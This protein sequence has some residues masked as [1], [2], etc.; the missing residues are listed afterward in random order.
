M[1]HLRVRKQLL[2]Y[3]EIRVVLFDNFQVAEPTQNLFVDNATRGFAYAK[4][5]SRAATDLRFFH[6]VLKHS[7]IDVAKRCELW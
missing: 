6:I 3:S 5:D 2:K 4:R 1:K 7:Q